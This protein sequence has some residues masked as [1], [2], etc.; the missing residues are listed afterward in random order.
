M[1]IEKLD[2]LRSMLCKELADIVDKDSMTALSLDTVDKLLHSIKNLDK[3]VMF[4]EYGGYSR[5]DRDGYDYSQ[6]GRGRM[7]AHR[8][9]LGR[10]AR[11]NSYG[12]GHSGDNGNSYRDSRFG[13]NDN[14]RLASRLMKMLEENL[15][16]DEW[17]EICMNM[18]K[19]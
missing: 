8:D 7:N 5:S 3:I 17:N 11:D 6:R 15:T 4:E 9:S 1:M 16:P 2:K 19:L 13:E 10:Y 18:Q 14:N 12:D